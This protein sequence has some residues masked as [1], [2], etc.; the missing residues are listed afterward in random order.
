MCST[1]ALPRAV[2]RTKQ[3]AAV[4]APAAAAR[5]HSAV[6]Q[7]ASGAATCAELPADHL[8]AAGPPVDRLFGP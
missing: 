7:A 8:E 3:L 6:L 1:H 2:G 5:K 4:P